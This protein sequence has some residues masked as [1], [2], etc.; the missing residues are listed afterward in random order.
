MRRCVDCDAELS[1]PDS[2]KQAVVC[3]SCQTINPVEGRLATGAKPEADLPQV[4]ADGHGLSEQ[5][6]QD[7]DV[8]NA[9]NGRNGHPGGDTPEPDG[10]A[11]LDAVETV[12]RRHVAFPSDALVAVVVAWVA[13]CWLIEAF[14]TTPRL[15]VLSPEKGS[16][17]TRV[18]EV[19]EP[20]LPSADLLITPSSSVLFRMIDAAEGRYCVLLDECDAYLGARKLSD[21]QEQVR[22]IVNSGYRRGASVARN[23]V[24]GKDW[25]PRRFAVFAPV[26]LAGIGDLPD[27]ILDRSV[28]VAMKRRRPQ[29]RVSPWRER[30][31]E[32]LR[33]LQD[34]LAEW[35]EAHINEAVALDSDPHFLP[36]GIEDRTADVWGPLIITAAVASARWHQRL[37]DASTELIASTQTRSASLGVRLLSDIHVVF[38]N[39]NVEALLKALHDLEDAP[40]GDLRGEPIQSRFLSRKLGDYDVA[41]R[42]L[43]L[44]GDERARGYSV[45]HDTN[46]TGGLSD[47]FARYLAIPPGESV[48]SVTPVPT[49]TPRVSVTSV[50]TATDPEL[51]S[52]FSTEAAAVAEVD[53]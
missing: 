47:A 16:G 30:M 28:V 9:R 35:G 11:L 37:V 1:D 13:H 33:P 46:G 51:V 17:K 6:H 31:K 45:H 10:G 38:N 53:L 15:A 27:T 8:R 40:W 43:N 50:T 23:E 5:D 18:L 4:P 14:D 24:S 3:L 44:G 32:G 34:Q 2:G 29:D 41:P 25:K 39:R 12:L 36:D 26:A 49:G 42:L 21:E 19:I 52:L 48:T 22:A 20:M 7:G